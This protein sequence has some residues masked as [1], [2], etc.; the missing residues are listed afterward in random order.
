MP[1]IQDM[2]RKGQQTQ[3]RK[4]KAKNPRIS[5]RVFLGYTPEQVRGQEV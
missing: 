5:P 2:L 1:V 3:D 4:H